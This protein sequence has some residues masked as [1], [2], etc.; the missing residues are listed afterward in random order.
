MAVGAALGLARL[1]NTLVGVPT[2]RDL[3]L[4]LSNAVELGLLAWVIYLTVARTQAT[5][6]ILRQPLMVDPT[7]ISAFLVIGEQG[8]ILALLFIGGMTLSLLF[9]LLSAFDPGVFLQIDFWLIYIP[10]ALMPVVIFFLAM[11]PTHRVLAEAKASQLLEVR[12]ELRRASLRLLEHLAHDQDT[13][14]V[15]QQIAALATL[16]QRLQVARTWPYN[17]TMLRTLFVSVMAPAALLIIRK[18]LER[19]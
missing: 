1:G 19:L 11:R 17:T 2:W 15:T 8:L 18:V 10:L 16:E 9:L 14:P 4:L 7:E 13:Y 12:R 6:T 3:Y 5:A